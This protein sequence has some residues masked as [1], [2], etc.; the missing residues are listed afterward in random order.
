ML[1]TTITYWACA[2]MILDYRGFLF[3]S[4]EALVSA[5]HN[6]PVVIYCMS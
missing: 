5:L 2:E 1:I 6:G 4:F 3:C